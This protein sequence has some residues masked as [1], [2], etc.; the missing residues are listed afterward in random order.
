MGCWNGTCAVSNLHVTAGQK[1]MVLMLL[2]NTEA[3]S[4]CY[5]N[6]LY[7]VCPVPFYGKYNDYGAVEDCEGFGLNIVIEALRSRLYEFGQ[8]PNSSHDIVVNQANFNI[9]LLFDADHEDRL[10]IQESPR[11][12]SDEYNMHELKK[13]K[14]EKNGL[15]PEQNFELDRLAN[16]IKKVDTFRQVTHIII[17]GDILDSILDKWYIEDYIGNGEGTTGYGKNYNHLY[18]KDMMDSIPEYMRRIKEKFAETKAAENALKDNANL[19]EAQISQY[20]SAIFHLSHQGVFEWN[21]PC[22]AGK[23]MNGFRRGEGSG[24]ALIDVDEY[25]REYIKA[26][27]WD[28]LESFVREVLT[29]AWVN[30]FMAHTRKLWT[31]QS[32][33]G[34]QNSEHRPYELL[35][36]AVLDVIK[37]EKA[38]Y[39]NEEELEDDEADTENAQ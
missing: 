9:D 29:T 12:N 13:Q 34:S 28:G 15:S 27:D 26:E 21:D 4:F 19:T 7:E 20:R 30:S 17:H 1:V 6:A 32:G 24:W 16:K 2:K 3:R 38:E 31:K 37:A 33:A 10:G 22:M 23:W 8:G 11:W 5:G 39:G 25:V 18:F 36:N 14:E 35:A